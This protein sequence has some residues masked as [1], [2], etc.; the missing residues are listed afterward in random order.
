MN[1]ADLNLNALKYFIDSI[2]LNS[3][4]L[5]AEKNHIS[6]SAISQA[7]RR[8]EEIIGFDV[9]S[10]SKNELMLTPEGRR[11]YQRA[12]IGVE[13]FQNSVKVDS[14]IE[15]RL[16]IACSGALAEALIIPAFKKQNNLKQTQIR[17]G[18]TSKVRQLVSEGT[19]NLGF[20]VDDEA[21]FGLDF[22]QIADGQFV[23]RSKRGQ[24]IEPLITSEARPETH[25]LLK[26]LS[27]RKKS[28]DSQIE[29][30]SWSIAQKLAESVGGS[31]LVPDFLPLG[32]L[33]NILSFTQIYSYRIL[34]IFKNENR[35]S[36]AEVELLKVV[37][38]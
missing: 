15:G 8:I 14:R 11:F 21:T 6:R 20:I 23:L 3:L 37:Q 31:C 13:S 9:I 17:I 4:T 30:E 35:L 27:K 28:Y 22:K 36:E 5:A 18:I 25:V 38:R 19:V 2:E 29:I 33:K 7:I 26:M 10:H 16:K 1:W 34:A 12:K 24:F 32:G